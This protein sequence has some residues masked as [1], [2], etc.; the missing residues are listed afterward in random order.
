M[1]NFFRKKRYTKDIFNELMEQ[2]DNFYFDT[3][4]N[5]LRIKNPNI[6]GSLQELTFKS[7][8]NP[9][10]GNFTVNYDCITLGGYKIGPEINCPDSLDEDDKSAILTIIND[11]IAECEETIK[12]CIK[13]YEYNKEYV[14][15]PSLGVT[16]DGRRYHFKICLCANY[17]D[18]YLKFIENK[19]LEFGKEYIK[20][21][22][23]EFKKTLGIKYE[24][25]TV[26]IVEPY[27]TWLDTNKED[28]IKNKTRLEENK[29]CHEIFNRI[30]LNG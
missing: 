13:K 23:A 27:L 7:V 6:F 28:I 26:V 30:R 3:K 29:K 11:R 21:V 25:D 19:N 1:F 8:E 4:T 5:Y 20:Y 17:L 2:K 9:I 14:M 15:F 22:F 24:Y 12:N 18:E 10:S 16:N